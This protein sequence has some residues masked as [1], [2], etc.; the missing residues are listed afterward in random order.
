MGFSVDP[1]SYLDRDDAASLVAGYYDERAGV[2]W[3][4]G[5]WFERL[6]GPV[7]APNRITPADIAAVALL[8]VDIPTRAANWLL[9]EGSDQIAALLAQIP[10]DVELWQAAARDQ[11]SPG[12]PADQLWH[13][14]EARSGIGWVTA[15]KLCAR[16]RPALLPVYDRVVRRALRPD[17]G[18]WMTLHEWFQ[19][20][21]GAVDRLTVIKAESGAPSEVPLLRI[22]DVV[23][24]M[25]EHGRDYL[26]GANAPPEH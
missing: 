1:M 16:K 22:L 25:A 11:I 7:D 2:P 3:F 5:A 6:G 4:T 8:S 15:G 26:P 23:I 14:F 24:W 17:Q 13:L 9:H 20:T 21:P 19:G 18:F 12:R 10:P